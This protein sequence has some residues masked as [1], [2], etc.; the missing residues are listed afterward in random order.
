MDGRWKLM[1]A[2]GILAGA[3]G[4]N[5][6]S[7]RPGDAAAQMN[8]VTSAQ[9]AKAAPPP[10]A[11]PP[12]T[13]LNPATYISMGQLTEQAANEPDRPQADRDAFRRQAR[14]SYLKA[15]EVDPKYAPAYVALGASYMANGERDQA[16]AMFKKA[17]EIAPKDPSLWSELGDV[18][19]R[20]KDWPAAVASLT[21]AV[22]LDPGNRP[23]ETRLG[24]TL[25]RA[26]KYEDALNALAK[27][28]PEAEARY[29]VARMMRHNQHNDEADVQLQLALRADPDFQ[30]ARELLADHRPAA[31]PGI[32]QA[33]Y[34]QPTAAPAAAPPPPLPPVQLGG[35]SPAAVEPAPIGVAGNGQ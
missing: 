6:M 29:N 13:N 3:V 16:Q 20:C 17:T 22:Q 33:S 23:L 5:S 19:A 25:A 21:R 32:K 1:L 18:Q 12:R 11:E 7:K 28:M 14:Q 9:M 27:V 2:G 8:A 15:I 4:C 35:H 30:A 34:Q 31:D 10:P 24:L 26:G